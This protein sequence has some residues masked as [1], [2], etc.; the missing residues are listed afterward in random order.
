ME[1]LFFIALLIIIILLFIIKSRQKDT[2][3]RTHQSFLSLKK[4]LVELKETIKNLPAKELPV[5]QTDENVVQWRPYI[6][7]IIEPQISPALPELT[8]VIE[9]D[10]FVSSPFTPKS[11]EPVASPK[12]PDLPPYVNPLP[13]ENWWAKWL[14]N[15]PDLEKFIGENL[16]NKIGITVL[17]L[18]IAFFVKYAIDQNWIKEAG[19]VSIGI[20]CG[21]ALTGL[22]HY[23]RNT[24][25]S[26]SSVLAGGGIAV[27]YFTIAFAFH[28][29]QLFSQTAAFV[30][31]VVI[32]LFAVMLSLGYDKLELAVIAAI[33][34]F[35]TPFLISSGSGNYII[36]FTYLLILNMGMLA[37]AWFKKWQAINVIALFFTL[38]I[39]GGWLVQNTLFGNGFLLYKNSMVFATAFYVLFLG[40]G[41]VNN[42]RNQQ[43]F[44]A[45]DF[46][47]LM[48]V[49]FSY[50]AAG[51][52]NLHY[53]NEGA[54]Q[55]LFTIALGMI[56]FCLAA[57]FYTSNKGDKNLL[58]LLIG[59]TLT[60]ISL[61]APVQLH[62]HTITLFWSA[63]FVLLYWL[64]QRSNIRIFKYSSFIILILMLISLLM[65]WK[66]ANDFNVN[67]L[68]VI[69][70]SLQGFI[71]NIVAVV[72]FTFYA[73][74]LRK[75]QNT[76][77]YVAG[78]KNNVAGTAMIMIAVI[79]L[80]LTGVFGAN[81]YFYNAKTLD[82]PN[83]WHQLI[84]YLFTALLLWIINRY[85]LSVTIVLQLLLI[86]GCVGM[87]LLSIPNVIR[88]RNG[89]LLDQY[90]AIQ[91]W[92]HWLADM[93]LIYLLYRAIL[94][95]RN[96]RSLFL[97]ARNFVLWLIN[98]VLIAFFSVECM[99]AYV[100]LTTPLQ[101]INTALQQYL[102]AGLTIVW[103][104]CSFAIMWLGM[105]H[106]YK[107]L[108]IISLS[109]FSL[110]LVK[111]FLFDIRNISEGGKIAAFIM[112]GILLLIISFMYQKLK[113]IIIDDTTR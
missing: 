43:P 101:N 54:Y 81:L 66:K 19:R 90:P 87:Y 48:L 9:K 98:I 51:V 50:Y 12:E 91:F 31:M 21:I 32:T 38:C 78:V 86:A 108:R 63:E 1:A 75:E 62:G 53:W 45:F 7:P 94:L 47:L 67:H 82:I 23:L 68:M 96:Y 17:V 30:I 92:V 24:Y 72:A 52:T 16:I 70:K 28:E 6:P 112:L 73:V 41:M 20:G 104:L 37:L 89:V 26:F 57:Y 100:F 102:K 22:A 39:Y 11:E 10:G 35:I 40:M 103:A 42:I 99:H 95:Y 111:L 79:I 76:T 2:E 13:S 29:Y 34:G 109:L 71:T 58:Y 74:L 80:Y 18:G 4:E 36:L 93:L 113:K 49:T 85:R 15:N 106:K 33:G 25:R 107:T 97:P 3:N 56:N 77:V 110:A 84:T 69:Y 83:T 88:L 60:F 65:D 59:L 46:S 27:F 61:A 8:P 105:K 44:K 14:R 55:G 64:H 5:T